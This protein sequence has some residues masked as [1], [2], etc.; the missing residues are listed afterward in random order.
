VGF[1]ESS[2]VGGGS[3][4]PESIR[5]KMNN[6]VEYIDG[7]DGRKEGEGEPR[8]DLDGGWE[9]GDLDAG[10]SGES[11]LVDPAEG[12]TGGEGK[13]AGS[14]RWIDETQG[15]TL[16]DEIKVKKPEFLTI[17]DAFP[18][19]KTNNEEDKTVE[20]IVDGIQK[21]DGTLRDQMEGHPVRG[22]SGV[23]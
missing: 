19:V 14:E 8:K 18:V 21:S 13:E 9:H 5:N 17:S 11:I 6:M 20:E 2:W 7:D 22:D 16:G 1:R 23:E 3:V 12:F 15:Q 4:I 10:F